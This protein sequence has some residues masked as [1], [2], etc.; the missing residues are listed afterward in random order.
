MC[1]VS[2][3]TEV[4][5]SPGYISLFSLVLIVSHYSPFESNPAHDN[6][7]PNM[8]QN[9]SAPLPPI[10]F[11]VVMNP[12]SEQFPTSDESPLGVNDPGQFR[13][14]TNRLSSDIDLE[15]AV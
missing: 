6:K 11:K 1:F 7:P 14:E 3:S 9:S 10:Q 5:D 12:A 2:E 8:K 13:S 4:F 15:S